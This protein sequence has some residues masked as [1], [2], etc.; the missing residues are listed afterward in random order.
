MFVQ[1]YLPNLNFAV[2]KIHPDP[3]ILEKY[4]INLESVL[5]YNSSNSKISAFYPFLFFL[6]SLKYKRLTHDYIDSPE[7]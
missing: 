3:L 5:N 6:S 1:T 2:P 4:A 7:E